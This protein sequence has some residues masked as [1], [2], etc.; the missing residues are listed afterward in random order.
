MKHLFA[1]L[2]LPLL[3]LLLASC[4]QQPPLQA[5]RVEAPASW[6][7]ANGTATPD[8]AGLLD[9]QLA[10]LQAQA[11]NANRDIAQAALRMKQ[12]Q[13]VAAQAG[14]RWAP[15]AGLSTNASRPLESQ[16]GSR[17][18]DIGGVSVPV[19]TSVGTSRSYGASIGVGYELDLWDRLS[20]AQAAQRANVE[21]ARS[22]I[23]AAR[24]LIQSRV[25]EAYWTL[26]AALEQRPLAAQQVALTRE[27]LPLVR[28]RVSEGKLQPIEVD[29]AATSVQAAESRLADLD[30]DAQSQRHQLAVLLAEPL[31]GPALAARLPP[32]A[33]ARWL[34]A[35]PAEVLERR[36]DVQ[37]GRLA[38]D[39][40]LARLKAS[41]ADRY[42]RLSFSGSVSTGGTRLSDWLSQP[43]GSLAANLAVPLIDWQRLGLQ[44]DASRTD[45]E[46]AAVALRDTLAKALADIEAQRIDAA[47]IA[48]QLDA[49]ASR[50]Q[51]STEAN[52]LAALRLE[53][54]T[55]ARADALQAQSA[56]LDAEQGRIRLR[57]SQWLNQSALFKAL[58]GA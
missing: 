18:V 13:L 39:A 40:A 27:I 15:S 24:L 47:R 36:P 52:R 17:S 53:V 29:K 3:P 48:Q 7:L 22:D 6:S 58:G 9:P 54:G 57:L 16:T 4:A 35:S 55:L 12:A 10:A 5:P 8:W 34:L 51:E 2:T 11:L 37:R 38:V 33:P 19:A 14:L 50:L 42:P 31:P 26:G 28:L 43:L 23:N 49:N 56:R 1:C 30:A 21:S 20:N 46:L 45:L 41:E 32:G 44:R 25:A